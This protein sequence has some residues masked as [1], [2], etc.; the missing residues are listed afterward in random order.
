[1]DETK[2][3][4]PYVKGS[5]TSEAAA[6]AL[7]SDHED[8]RKL[9]VLYQGGHYT[10]DEAFNL[11]GGERYNTVS[12]RVTNL[13]QAGILIRTGEKRKTSRGRYAEVLMLAPGACLEWYEEWANGLRPSAL[14]RGR[15]RKDLEKAAAAY[16]SDPTP[17]NQAALLSTTMAGKEF[18]L[19]DRMRPK[20]AGHLSDD[21]SDLDDDDFMSWVHGEN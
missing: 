5:E 13:H 6:R 21:G 19:P 15:W 7:M 12:A 1:M 3:R 4:I 10:C 16:A 11:L 18:L 20:E 17:E 14:L 9:I 2:N 8:V